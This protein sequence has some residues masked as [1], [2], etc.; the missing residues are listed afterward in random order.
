MGSGFLGYLMGV[1]AIAAA[2]ENAVALLVWL[3]LGGVFFSDAT[4]TLVRRS[5]RGERVHEAHRTHAYQ[6]LARRWGSHRT[7]TGA[8]LIVNLVW[9]LPCA[10]VASFYPRFAMWMVVIALA[11]IALLALI[12][13]AGRRAAAALQDAKHS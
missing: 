10:A 2:R 3:I 9:L 6:W 11:P 4:V 12:A 7:V 1:L 5:L 8:V 13:G